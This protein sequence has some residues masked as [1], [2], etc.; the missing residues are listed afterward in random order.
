MTGPSGGGAA[1]R[2]SGNSPLAPGAG[3]GDVTAEPVNAMK[4]RHGPH[5]F[6]GKLAQYRTWGRNNSPDYYAIHQASPGWAATTQHALLMSWWITFWPEER[7][8]HMLHEDSEW[9]DPGCHF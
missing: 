7:F 5:V 6:N 2:R 8:R 9:Q 3:V 4:D 1:A